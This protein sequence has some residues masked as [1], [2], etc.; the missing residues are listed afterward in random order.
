MPHT[1]AEIR[2]IT[3]VLDYVEGKGIPDEDFLVCFSAQSWTLHDGKQTGI[4]GATAICPRTGNTFPITLPTCSGFQA[5]LP[6]DTSLPTFA[7]AHLDGASATRDGFVMLAPSPTWPSGLRVKNVR[8]LPAP[9][10]CNFSNIEQAVVMY[11]IE[12]LRMED[13]CYREIAPDLLP[14]LKQ[15]DYRLVSKIQITF[16]KK[17]LNYVEDR[18]NEVLES[19]NLTPEMRID[20]GAWKGGGSLRHAIARTLA[21]SGLR[22]SRKPRDIAALP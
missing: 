18:F 17:V 13:C 1:H 3:D 5:T 7:I 15:L 19:G 6:D 22:P 14:G 9:F 12:H 2:S 20:Y 10:D 8:F 4:V 16:K 21:R 11:A